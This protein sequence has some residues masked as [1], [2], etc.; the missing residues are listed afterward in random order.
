M[1]WFGDVAADAAKIEEEHYR[2]KKLGTADNSDIE[3]IGANAIK[4]LVFMVVYMFLS[5]F[6]S[7]V[8]L[9]IPIIGYIA[10]FLLYALYYSLFLFMLKWNYNQEILAYFEDNTA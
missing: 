3:T 1:F 4:K 5:I 9:R 7:F 6:V 2:N 8:V 10:M